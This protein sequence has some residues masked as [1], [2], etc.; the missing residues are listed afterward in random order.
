MT[1][2]IVSVSKAPVEAE[3]A[4]QDLIAAGIPA[5]SI[6]RHMQDGGYLVESCSLKTRPAESKG[7]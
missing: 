3:S 1:E 4:V 6:D 5:T 2:T 7:F